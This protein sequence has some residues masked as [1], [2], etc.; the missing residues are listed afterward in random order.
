MLKHLFTLIWNKKKQNALLISEMLISFLVIFAVCSLLVYYYQNYKKPMGLEYEH[1]WVV[2]YSNALKTMNND[3]LSLYYESLRKLLKS[4]PEVKEISFSSANIPFS[5]TTNQGA[6]SR[7]IHKIAHVNWY[8][9][10]DSYKNTLQM[11]VLEGRWFDK[12]DAVG[13]ESH[14]VINESLK[15][16]AFGHGDAVG[17]FLS[18]YDGKDGMKVIGVIQDVK[19]RGDYAA[20]GVSVYKQL[21]TAAFQWLSSILISVD[22]NASAAFESHLYKTIANYMKNANVEIEHLTNKRKNANY[23]TLV[24]MIVLLVVACFLVINVALGLFGVLWYN[25]NKRRGEIG[26]R[27]AV[28]A[29]GRSVSTQLVGEALVLATLSLILGTFFAIQFPLLNIFDLPASIYITAIILS[30]AFI[31][32]LVLICSLYPGKQAAAIYPAVAL[33]EE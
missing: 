5:Q 3:S 8:Q 24:P 16:E 26:L 20:S 2:N 13:K 23:F 14:V 7:D 15:E 17:K 25:I 18:T 33:H 6:L 11:Q 12:Q 27:R 10:E 1:V 22:A 29:T 31:Y 4:M 9:V 30:I 19:V 32:T 21:D 28:G